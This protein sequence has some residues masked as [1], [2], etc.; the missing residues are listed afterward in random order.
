MD[1]NK[2]LEEFIEKMKKNELSNNTIDAYKRDASKFIMFLNERDENVLDIDMVSIMAYVQALKKEGRANSSIIR[3]LVAVRSFYKYLISAGKVNENPFFNYEVPKNKRNFPQ[4]L[5]IDEVDRFLSTPDCN[6]NKGIRDKA[7]LELMYATGIK[8][9]EL[10][11]LTIFD[12]NLKLSY[13]RCKGNNNKERIIPIG[14]YAVNCL[15]EYIKIKGK[16]YASDS[17]LLFSNLRGEKMTR[18]G[19]WKLVKAYAKEANIN[20]KI[21]SYTLRHSFAVHLLQNGADMK[22]VQELLGHNTITT[23]QIYSS[24]SRQNKIADIYKKAHPRA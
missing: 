21:N 19:F 24:V 13:I 14:N 17:E 2:Y 10:L 12:V 8:V 15:K 5:T 22:A 23:T 20:K 4:T 11:N 16:L 1:K 7:M 9:S 6:D 3:N 18:Q